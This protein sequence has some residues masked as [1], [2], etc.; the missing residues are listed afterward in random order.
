[1]K[2]SMVVEPKTASPRTRGSAAESKADAKAEARNLSLS[3]AER[4]REPR[5]PCNDPVE[6][7]TIPGDGQRVTA[8][9]LDVSRSGLRL[10]VGV[11]LI[12]G[13]QIEILLSKQLAI[14]GKV[15][16]CRR[17]GDLYEAGIL[18]EEAFYSSKA[19]EHIALEQL[20]SYLTGNGLT[21]PQVIKVREHL[22]V[23]STCRM[24]MV[25]TYTLNP[26]SGKSGR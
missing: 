25:E 22:A 8:K 7:R 20:T 13:T 2:N 14:F 10:E 3:G 24:R 15:R 17:A 1:M 18:I 5:Y 11:A 26:K 16:H 21:L 23:C 12:R 6:L 19:G 4:R 9:L